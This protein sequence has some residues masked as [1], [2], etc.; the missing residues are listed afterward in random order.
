[1]HRFFVPGAGKGPQA[2]LPES[3]ARHALRVL[4]LESDAAVTLLDG[5]GGEFLG[6]LQVE[7]RDRASVWIESTRRH[8]GPRT[9]VT[10][11]QAIAKGPAMEGLIHRA[12]ELGCRRL[13]PLL[14]ERSISRP[15]A[16]NEKQAKWQ[17]L[18]DE[19][20]KQSGNPWRMTVNAPQPPAAWLRQ[21][22]AYELIL[23][24]SLA[25][26]P[27]LP[28]VAL[29]GF[30]TSHRRWPRTVALVI[31]PEGDFTPGEYELFRKSGAC[32]FTLGPHV[33]RVETAAT[34]ALAVLQNL[35]SE[36]PGPG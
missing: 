21:S 22:A 17:T 11:A 1:M 8:D 31:G 3:E 28:R 36:E 12:V 2:T 7:G 15:D 19:A 20:L 24:A 29:D 14:A 32:P 5:E 33:L 6:R 35:L 23:V 13:V 34:A 25:D 26:S 30:R 16:G 27:R 18:A 9:E 10:L 4:R